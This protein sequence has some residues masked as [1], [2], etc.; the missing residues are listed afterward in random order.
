MP[1]PNS[2]NVRLKFIAVSQNKDK[3]DVLS[4]KDVIGIM[5]SLTREEWKVSIET[6]IKIE[7]KVQVN[8]FSYQ[9]EK[10]VQ[11]ENIYYRVERTFIGGQFIELYLSKTSLIEDDFIWPSI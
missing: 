11:I 6:K 1:F 9:N 3:Y 4:S 2:P 7:I 10:F 5:R 8:A